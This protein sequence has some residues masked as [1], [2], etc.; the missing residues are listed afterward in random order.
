MGFIVEK[1]FIY[2]GY[3]CIVIGTSMGHRC[4]Y[5]EIPEGNPLYEKNYDEIDGYINVHGGWTYSEYGNETYPVAS[6]NHSW[7]IGFDCAHLYDKPDKELIEKLCDND[8]LLISQFETVFAKF[9]SVGDKRSI[10]TTEY[11]V[12]ELRSA[13]KQIIDESYKDKVDTK[14][15]FN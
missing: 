5:I 12:N 9:K 10:K 15:N 3:R 14:E 11:V 6:D 2:C 7:F 8:I 4:G 1:D 13:V